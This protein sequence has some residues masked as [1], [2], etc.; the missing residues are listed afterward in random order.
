MRS[1]AQCIAH[2][3]V[4]ATDASNCRLLAGKIIDVCAAE[5]HA[6]MTE[7]LHSKLI[8]MWHRTS[9]VFASMPLVPSIAIGLAAASFVWHHGRLA[10]WIW[11]SCVLFAIQAMYVAY[12]VRLS[13]VITL[14]SHARELTHDAQ[15]QPR[16]R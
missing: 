10:V 15:S 5:G 4:D 12:Q 1:S 11:L 9:E 13:H 6:L 3:A 2:A 14:P 7:L 8:S 16:W